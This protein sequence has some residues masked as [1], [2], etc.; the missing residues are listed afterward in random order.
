LKIEKKD[1]K[2]A[3]D[4]VNENYKIKIRANR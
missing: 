2:K 3:G 1:G 4:Q